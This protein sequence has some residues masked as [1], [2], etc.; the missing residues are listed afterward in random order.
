MVVYR[1]DLE[2]QAGGKQ[3]AI[4]CAAQPSAL[5]AHQGRQDPKCSKRR[6]VL[7][8]DSGSDQDR[9]VRCSAAQRC[10]AAQRLE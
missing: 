5:A 10:K 7:I 1:L 9:R 8:D 2:D 6:G 4:H 3:F